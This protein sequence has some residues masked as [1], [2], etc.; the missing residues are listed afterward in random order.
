MALTDAP[1][2]RARKGLGFGRKLVILGLGGGLA[3]AGSESLRTKVLDTLF[4]K[5]EE[6]QYTPPPAPTPPAS[7]VSAASAPPDRRLRG[8]LP[9]APLLFRPRRGFY[10]P[11]VEAATA[12]A[13]GPQPRAAGGQGGPDRRGDAGQRRARGI[14]GATFDHVAREA[15]VSR[16]LLHYYFGTK[17]RLLVEVVRRES[18]VRIDGMEA[19]VG[20]ASDAE[21]V[22]ARSCGASRTSSGRGTR[23]GHALRADDPAPAQPRD[24]RRARR[25]GRRTR[26]HMAAALAPRRGGG[27][28]AAGRPRVVATF[29]FAWPTGHRPQAERARRSTSLR[30]VDAVDRRG[31]RAA[32]LSPGAAPAA[33]QPTPAAPHRPARGRRGRRPLR[34]WPSCS[35]PA[36]AAQRLRD[37]LGAS[38]PGPRCRGHAFP[39]IKLL[40]HHA[41]HVVIRMASYRSPAD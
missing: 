12:A 34:C 20:G 18:D 25:V 32:Q 41:D 40:W 10:I 14:A 36:I 9:G 27:E 15:G 11:A 29:L 35:C 26:G 7:P 4:G 39:A 3:L 6:F 23:R 5:E 33:A 1:K 8:A 31:P 30:V 2:Q 19:A 28:P 24:R 21:A 37:R 16:G 13:R 38:R 22:L 17:E